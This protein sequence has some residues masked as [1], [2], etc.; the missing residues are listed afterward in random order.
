[1][2]YFSGCLFTVHLQPV[3]LA[4]TYSWFISEKTHRRASTGVRRAARWQGPAR[5]LP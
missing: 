5:C 1:M 3:A 2:S 4:L